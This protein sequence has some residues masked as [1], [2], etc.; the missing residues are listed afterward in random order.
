MTISIIVFIGYIAALIGI[1][2]RT[3]L[4]TKSHSDYTLA[5]RSNN[6]WVAAISAESS[7]M[8]GWLLMGLPGS[9]YAA[10]FQ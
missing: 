1:G 7:D 9:A 6:K 4:K 5:G 3:Y 2:L 8:S 10:G